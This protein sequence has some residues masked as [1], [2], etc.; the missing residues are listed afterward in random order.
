MDAKREKARM[1]GRR[2][3][4]ESVAAHALRAG[5]ADA[6]VCDLL[7]F[8]AVDRSVGI[9]RDALASSCLECLLVLR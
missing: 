1:A 3:R 9:C 5:G 2:S 4:L 8:H 7:A 6:L